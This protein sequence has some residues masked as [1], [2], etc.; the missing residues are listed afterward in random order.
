[1]PARAYPAAPVL[2]V[3]GV[4]VR[5][6]RVLLIQRGQPP[7]AGL[8]TLPG[9]AVEAGEPVRAALIREVR[10]ETG[11]SVT[12]GP[13]VEIFEF[14]ERDP[15]GAV[16]F[17]YVILDFLAYCPRADTALAASDAAA[18]AWVGWDRLADYPTTAGLAPVLEKARRL[19]AAS[20]P[21]EI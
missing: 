9:G 10:E 16:Q 5:D 20:P 13:L 19:A 21:A 8:W 7:A 11:L 17:H 15:A 3:A 18:L 2:A 12:P 4:I 14:L 1:M 6:A